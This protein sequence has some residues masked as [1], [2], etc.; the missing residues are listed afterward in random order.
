MTTNDI[1]LPDSKGTTLD[2]LKT[3]QWL[4][5]QLA[6]SG[7]EITPE[8]EKFY[9]ELQKNLVKKIDALDYLMERMEGQADLLKQKAQEYLAASKTLTNN[10]E[11]LHEM[12]KQGMIM[13]GI[14]ELQG[15]AVRYRVCNAK[16]RL[17]INGDVPTQYKRTVHVEEIQ[18]DLIRADLEQGKELPFAKLVESNSLRR[19]VG[20]KL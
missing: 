13:N 17:D 14:A 15:H 7:G 4:E 11:R 3:W 6:S 18:K 16:P 12:L 5:W 8:L 10:A 9:F 20:V 2:L 1:T 19:Y